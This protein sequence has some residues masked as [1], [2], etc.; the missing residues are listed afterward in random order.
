VIC[1]E[2][3]LILLKKPDFLFEGH[4]GGSTHRL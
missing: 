4:R 2:P 3:G 1:K